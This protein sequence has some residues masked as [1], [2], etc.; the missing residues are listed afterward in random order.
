MM[1]RRSSTILLDNHVNK[2]WLVFPGNVLEK[3][4]G[5]HHDPFESQD[6]ENNL[7]TK[8]EKDVSDNHI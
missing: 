5:G 7:I 3:D 2:K 8:E 4:R 1:S 6:M